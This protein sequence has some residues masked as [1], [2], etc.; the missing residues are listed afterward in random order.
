MDEVIEKKSEP[1][2]TSPDR[3]EP[4]GNSLLTA[5]PH[6]AITA[7]TEGE[8]K[9]QVSTLNKFVDL[10]IKLAKAKHELE[11][12]AI[13]QKQKHRMAM[14]QYIVPVISGVIFAGVGLILI[15]DPVEVIRYL[16]VMSFSIGACALIPGISKT[17][18]NIADVM[19]SLNNVAR[20]FK[21]MAAEAAEKEKAVE[22]TESPKQGE[23]VIK[24]RVNWRI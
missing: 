13:E 5:L 15:H 18:K 2:P 9:L 12:Q 3:T 16:G 7:R 17:F 6:F 24:E 23:A 1:H 20:N 22:S 19:R 21:E 4:I 11:S 8:A 14:L 10:E